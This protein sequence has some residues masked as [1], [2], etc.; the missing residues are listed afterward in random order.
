MFRWLGR[1]PWAVAWLFFITPVTGAPPSADQLQSWVAQLDADNFVAR[2]EACRNLAAAG[3]AA[4]EALTAGVVSSS[5]EAAWRA[6]SALEQIALNGNDATLQR[7]AAAL[8]QLN[9]HGKPGLTSVVKE[10]HSKQARVRQERAV[11]KI[12]ALGGKFDGDE[13]T[14]R[15]IGLDL[16]EPAG[17]AALDVALQGVAGFLSDPPPAV[18]VPLPD[19]P[20]DLPPN[21]IVPIADA[22]F[23]AIAEVFIADAFA[24]PLAA[25]AGAPNEAEVALTIDQDWRG[26]DSGLAALSDLPTIRSLSLHRAPLTDA[27][28]A[29]IAALPQLQSLD[30]ECTPLTGKSLSIFRQQR[31]EMRIFARGNAMLGV[32]ADMSGPC[33]LTGIFTGSGAGES[34]LKA[35]D[36]IIAVGGQMVGSFSDLTIAVF[37]HQP[38]EKVRVEFNRGGEKRAVEVLLKERKLVEATPR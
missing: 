8:E 12:R 16:A 38:G 11:A 30:V 14:N 29:Q 26:G 15:P 17:I 33:V 27:A 10:L 25:E 35:G 4:I 31:P 6:S 37:A 23:P 24:P 13:P 22:P 19:P 18:E 5:P 2:E 9:Q 3:E 32:N 36:E 20:P 34:G 28:L 1:M 7:V 21:E